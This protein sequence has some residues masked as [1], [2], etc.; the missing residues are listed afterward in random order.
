[1]TQAQLARRAD[2]TE[3]TISRIE[4]GKD[5]RASTLGR[6]LAGLDPLGLASAPEFVAQ[7]IEGGK[8]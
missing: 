7:L 4:A 1:M 5:P 6:V 2:V 3:S 8:R